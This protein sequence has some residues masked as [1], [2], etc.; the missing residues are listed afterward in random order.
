[1][2]CDEI[3]KQH[4]IVRPVRVVFASGIEIYLPYYVIE[5]I[6]TVDYFYVPLDPYA[7]TTWF[8]RLYYNNNEVIGGNH[9]DVALSML[10]WKWGGDGNVYFIDDKIGTVVLGYMPHVSI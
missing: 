8:N 2:N 3:R 9:M 4:N 5:T 7:F 10:G 1:M 6:L